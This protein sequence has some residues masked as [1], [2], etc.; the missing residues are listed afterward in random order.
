ML[1]L[2]YKSHAVCM[3]EC[4]GRTLEEVNLLFYHGVPAR[5]SAAWQPPM[6][7]DKDLENF[8]HRGEEEAPA[9]PM[10][11]SGKDKAEVA[12]MEEYSKP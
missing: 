4:R 1:S 3:P 9:L 12:E 7:V 5:K 2:K 6:E 10:D 8:A 11:H